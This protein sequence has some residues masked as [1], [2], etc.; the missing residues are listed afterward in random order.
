MS[1]TTQLAIEV[2][3]VGAMTYG[4]FM[5]VSRLMPRSDLPTQLF[6][7][8]ASLHLSLEL[9]GVNKWYLMHGAASYPSS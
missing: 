8:G 2:V 4:A 5:I 7:T 6:V 3:S 1:Y 9:M